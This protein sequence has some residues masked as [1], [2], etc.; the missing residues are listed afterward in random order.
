MR[1]SLA[2]LALLVVCGTC[3]GKEERWSSFAE[4]NDLSYYLD[5]QS[6]VPLPDNVY[7]FW[8]KSVAKDKE[9]FPREYNLS[10]ISYILTNYELDCAAA[11]YRIRGTILFDKQHKEINKVIAASPAAFEPVPPESLLELAQAE[12]CV[13]KES[14]AGTAAP[15]EE[16]VTTP[17]LPEAPAPALQPPSIM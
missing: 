2:V 7:I 12:I 5:L 15:E 3:R 9:Y 11:S 13:K 1:I 6:L 14:A 8:L 4:D 16:E 17:V 10:E